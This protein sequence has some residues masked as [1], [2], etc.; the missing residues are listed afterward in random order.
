MECLI[1]L[2][3]NKSGK[4]TIGVTKPQ[5]KA[6]HLASLHTNRLVEKPPV[7]RNIGVQN[8]EAAWRKGSEQK[9]VSRWVARLIIFFQSTDIY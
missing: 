1:N 6:M 3:I 5:L 7:G 4:V 8:K 9:A 2:A